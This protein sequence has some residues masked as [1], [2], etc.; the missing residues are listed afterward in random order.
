MATLAEPV[1]EGSVRPGRRWKQLVPHGQFLVRRE[2][3]RPVLAERGQRTIGFDCKRD[4]KLLSA[5]ARI[6]HDIEALLAK[7]YR[8]P[9]EV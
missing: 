6:A 2:G 9:W 8:K 3:H 4:L 5:A 7:E 1:R